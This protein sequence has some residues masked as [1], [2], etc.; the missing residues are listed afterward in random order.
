MIASMFGFKTKTKVA[1]IHREP[2]K[3]TL[4]EWRADEMMAGAAGKVLNDPTMRL[5]VQ[6]LYNSSPAWEV[7]TLARPEDRV[8]QQ[9]KIEGYTMALANLEALAKHQKMTMPVEATWE[10]EEIIP[11]KRL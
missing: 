4:D 7:L 9:C 3:L 11:V 8:A 1:L 5:M 2:F 6:V 10:P